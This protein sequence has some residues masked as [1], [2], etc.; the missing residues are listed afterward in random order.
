M[1][2]SYLRPTYI[3][4][5]QQAIYENVRQAKQRLTKKTQLFAVVKA[6][7][8]GHGLVPVARVCL[9]A[10]ATGFCVAT[11]DEALTLRA[12]QITAP[13]LV[14]SITPAAC[15]PVAASQHISLAVGDLTWLQEAQDVL[16]KATLAAPLAVHL[17]VD[18]GMGR[19]GFAEPAA[20]QEAAKFVL[21]HGDQ[22]DFEGVFTHFATADAEDNSYF[23]KQAAK[24]KDCLAALPQKPRFIHAANTATSLWHPDYDIN[25]VRLG[26]GIY[27]LNPS[28]KTLT[29]PYPLK[30]ALSLYSELNFI[31]KVPAGA[32]IGYGA[33]YTA[34]TA[35]W[36]GTIPIGYADGWQRRLSGLSVLIDGQRCPIVGRICMD[37]MMVRLPQVY[38]LGTKV[39]LIGQDGH[40]EITLD[41]LADYAGTINYEIACLLTERIPRRYLPWH[42]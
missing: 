23:Q 5:D 40:D 17:A 13:I 15:A 10:G 9:S 38:P 22:F 24:F 8:Y 31:K 3:E 7:A 25:L 27:G 12:A 28:G 36:I 26:I 6:D 42:A 37:Q 19:I 34:K 4:I 21:A 2:V 14:M 32:H 33:T 16:A 1:Q 35:E 18:S 41:D 20:L 30:P 29:A 39:T 11:L